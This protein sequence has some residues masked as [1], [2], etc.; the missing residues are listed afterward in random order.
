MQRA[1]D[2]ETQESFTAVSES[3][4]RHGRFAE[5][6]AAAERTRALDPLS[7]NAQ[8][9]VGTASPAAGLH[10]RAVEE[11]RQALAMGP[12][13]ARAFP[14]RVTYIAMGRLSDA[15][16]ELEIA[17]RPREDHNTRF[18]AFLGYAY[19]LAG[20][21]DDAREILKSSNSTVPSSTSRRSAL[22]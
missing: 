1:V 19:A 22:H 14:S 7:V 20:R 13:T 2:S 11:F 16:R 10:D 17:T 8:I 21:G 3:L 12:V 18:E 4:I 6:L 5:G 9:A 15:I